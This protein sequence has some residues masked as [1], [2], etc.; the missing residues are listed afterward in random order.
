MKIMPLTFKRGEFYDKDGNTVPLEFG[1]LEQIRIIEAIKE[2]KKDGRVYLYHTFRC[3]CGSIHEKVFVDGKE[4]KCE[5]GAKYQF[6]TYD[7][8]I[9]VLK[10]M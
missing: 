9:P 5:C 10:M 4:F 2:M 7:Y 6:S 1:N 3:F 8:D